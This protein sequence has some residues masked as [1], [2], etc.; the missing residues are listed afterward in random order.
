M[1]SFSERAE[2]NK[3][4]LGISSFLQAGSS[5]ACA[6][7]LL[8]QS[9]WDIL[10][11]FQKTSLCAQ[12]DLNELLCSQP[13]ACYSHYV[14]DRVYN[15][16]LLHLVLRTGNI[17]KNIIQVYFFPFPSIFSSKEGYFN[18]LNFF[19]SISKDSG[20]CFIKWHCVLVVG[21]Y[22]RAKNYPCLKYGMTNSGIPILFLI[23]LMIFIFSIYT[24][25][26]LLYQFSTVQQ[27]DPVSHTYICILFLT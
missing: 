16:S 4:H 14:T 27:S 20:I 19:F 1:F 18:F 22:V 10:A 23:F 21:L 7:F 24:W 3:L 8:P 9:S 17:K 26:T 25:F 2:T 5:S 13:R 15:L 11:F 6:D 12:T